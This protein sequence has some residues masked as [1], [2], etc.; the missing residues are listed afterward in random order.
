MTWQYRTELD[1]Y[2]MEIDIE[3]SGRLK[4]KPT[5]Q[6]LKP[7]LILFYL[8]LFPLSDARL[9]TNIPRYYTVDI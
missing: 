5:T 4:T 7:H 8:L 9:Y 6:V 2:T 1:H 3:R